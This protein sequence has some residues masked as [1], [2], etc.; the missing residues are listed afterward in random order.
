MKNSSGTDNTLYMRNKEG[1]YE[2]LVCDFDNNGNDYL[3]AF[4]HPHTATR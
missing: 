4:P 3:A 2:K 1:I